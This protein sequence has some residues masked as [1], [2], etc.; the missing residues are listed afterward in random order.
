MN[1]K[2]IVFEGLDASGKSTQAKLLYGYIKTVNEKVKFVT[3]PNYLE[4]SSAPV[5]MYLN[6]KISENLDDINSYAASSFFAIDRY[7]TYK[8][9][10]EKYYKNG[11][12]IIAD[13]YTTSNFIYQMSKLDENNWDNYLTWIQ[14][15]EYCKLD[16][17]KPDKVIYLR[18]PVLLSQK[19]LKE[20]ANYEIDLH[21]KNIEFLFKCRITAE[22]VYRKYNWLIVDCA[23]KGN[24]RSKYEVFKD[25]LEKL[26]D[27]IT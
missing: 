21:E 7:I 1:G 19:L 12:T 22:Y 23:S 16:L 20:R 10:W 3:F 6:S 11:Y 18:M 2:L 13:R 9:N 25:V 27:F 26:R 14:D 5:K 8:K 17:P 15:Y 24:P 4:D